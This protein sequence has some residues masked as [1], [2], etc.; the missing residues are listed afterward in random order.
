MSADPAFWCQLSQESLTNFPAA[1]QGS[2][3]PYIRVCRTRKF[4]YSACSPSPTTIS[5]SVTL[6]LH[7]GLY[8]FIISVWVPIPCSYIT[9]STDPIS[10]LPVAI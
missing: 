3:R 8:L 1:Q 7:V 10:P 5:F 9:P 4:P 6:N 2:S